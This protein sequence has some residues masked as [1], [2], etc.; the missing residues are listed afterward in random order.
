[1]DPAGNGIHRLDSLKL[2]WGMELYNQPIELIIV[3]S[4]FWTTPY[5]PPDFF[6]AG[7]P[8]SVLRDGLP[9]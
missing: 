7:N 2:S 5:F 6:P 3:S 8:A 1:A 4:Y 9:F